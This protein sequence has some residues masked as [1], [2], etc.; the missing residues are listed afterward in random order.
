MPFELAAGAP[1]RRGNHRQPAAA[2][3]SKHRRHEENAIVEQAERAYE[4]LVAHWQPRKPAT[5]PRSP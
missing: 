4:V 1:S 5:T 2:D 3:N